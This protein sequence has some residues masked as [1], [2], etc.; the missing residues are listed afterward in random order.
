MAVFK[1]LNRKAKAEAETGLSSTNQNGGRFF[2]KNG[3]PSVELKGM[4]FL[5]RLNIYHVLLSMKRW[6]FLLSIIAFFM[7]INLLFALLYLLIGVEHLAGMNVQ[8]TAEKIGEAFFF[9]AQ[10]FTTVGYGRIS[11][12]GFATS[13]VASL[14]ALTGLMSFALATGLLYGRFARPKTFIKYST[15]AL[16]AP[17][18]GGNAL[19]F[20][21]APYTRNYLMNVEVK[22]TAAMRVE[23]DGVIKNKFLNVTLDVAKAITLTL[24]WTIVHVIDEE[25]PFYGL[26]KED[27]INSKLELLVF[28][29]GFDESF[30][31]TVISRSSYTFDEL[32]YGARFVPMFNPNQDNTG[33]ELHMEK[34]D[35]YELIELPVKM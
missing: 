4:G 19:M 12:T 25:S 11:P 28:V 29:Q 35:E 10:T 18:K 32:V 6:K 8:S 16:F 14:E 15:H 33:T 3:N 13:F 34:L 17:F 1:K 20:R 23:E 5:E 21:F 26:S 22:V 24:N 30:S 9:S 7:G 2:D 31:N 27:I